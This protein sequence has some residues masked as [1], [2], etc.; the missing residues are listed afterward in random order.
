LT[1]VHDLPRVLSGP[2]NGKAVLQ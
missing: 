2:P 1:G